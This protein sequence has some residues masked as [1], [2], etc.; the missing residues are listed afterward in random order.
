MFFLHFKQVFKNEPLQVTAETVA[1]QF[2]GYLIETNKENLMTSQVRKFDSKG[3]GSNTIMESSFF[4]C[5][6]FN[7]DS[8]SS[9]RS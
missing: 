3:T 8:F 6:V 7:C 1:D 4:L 2:L 9:T 5:I